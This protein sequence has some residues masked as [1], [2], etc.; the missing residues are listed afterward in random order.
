MIHTR[1]ILFLLN[2][3]NILLIN[4]ILTREDLMVFKRKKRK[5]SEFYKVSN[6]ISLEFS[7][8]VDIKF[9]QFNFYHERV[10]KFSTRVS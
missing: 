8:H 1:N 4:R 6:F 3:V 5:S 10:Y 2:N 9:Q 7:C